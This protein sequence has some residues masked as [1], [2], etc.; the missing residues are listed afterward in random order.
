MI[1]R[2]NLL[3]IVINLV[4]FLCAFL[5]S[6]II[7]RQIGTTKFYTNFIIFTSYGATFL[8]LSG[9]LKETI[10]YCNKENRQF[11]YAFKQKI[12]SQK[13]KVIFALL[14]SFLLVLFFLYLLIRDPF[15]SFLICLGTRSELFLVN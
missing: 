9:A 5:T 7:V 15:I 3:P 13:K 6:I 1:T 10:L 8:F 11:I 14:I 4:T 12:I 2:K